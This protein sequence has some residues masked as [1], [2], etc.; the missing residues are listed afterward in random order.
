[1]WNYVVCIYRYFYFFLS[2]F[3]SVSCIIALVI[4]SCTMLNCS[5]KGGHTT[6]V[7]D[8][9]GKA[10]SLWPLSMFLAVGVCRCPLL[11]WGDSFL[12]LFYWVVLSETWKGA[13]VVRCLFCFYW[14]DHVFFVLHFI[15]V[16][17]Y[18]DWYFY[19]EPTLHFLV[20]FQL[21]MVDNPF[22]F[23]F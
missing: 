2:A 18:I 14:D 19:V 6:L 10:F 15:N 8:F 11:V 16:I 1:M 22:S 5:G 21:V 9:R 4:T 3:I 13:G 7:P 12:F 23:F 17:H 20:K